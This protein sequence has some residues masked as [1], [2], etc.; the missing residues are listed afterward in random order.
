MLPNKVL[1]RMTLNRKFKVVIAVKRSAGVAP[2]VNIRN[3][4]R[5]GEEACKRGIHNPGFE[6]YGSN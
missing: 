2:D 3:H 1:R 6:T 5:V 4:L